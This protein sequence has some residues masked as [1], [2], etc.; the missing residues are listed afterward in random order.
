MRHEQ[1]KLRESFD[2]I[3]AAEIWPQPDTSIQPPIGEFDQRPASAAPDVPTA[4]GRAIV[5]VY[6]GLIAIFFLTMGGSGE[7]R[8]MIAISGF[9]VAMFLG[10]PRLFFAVEK[11]PARRPDLR[12]FMARGIDTHTGRM[13]GGSALAQIFVV[14]VLLTAAI[15]AIGLAGLWILP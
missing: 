15:L 3:D 2:I 11:D 4:V 13:S 1:V 6:A 7:A 14:P 12:R 8:F 5:A 10:V 9:Y